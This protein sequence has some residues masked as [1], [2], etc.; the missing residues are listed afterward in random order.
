MG[1]LTLWLVLAAYPM[2]WQAEAQRR[3]ASAQT[4]SWAS[5]LKRSQTW[6]HSWQTCAHTPQR[7][8]LEPRDIR[9]TFTR[10]T[11]APRYLARKGSAHG[12]AYP[13]RFR[14]SS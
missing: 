7:L 14:G 9:S 5:S 10:Q 4:L 13:F 1:H 6:A 11:S 3:Q 2:R 12:S 8:Y